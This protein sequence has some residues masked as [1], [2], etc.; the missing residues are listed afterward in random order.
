MRRGPGRDTHTQPPPFQELTG[1]PGSLV[2][3]KCV[4]TKLTSWIGGGNDVGQNVFLGAMD[5]VISTLDVSPEKKMALND[6]MNE[7]AV[8]LLRIPRVKRRLFYPLGAWCLPSTR[9]AR[10]DTGW[11]L[12]PNPQTSA[13]QT[14]RTSEA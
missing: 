5:H 6:S 11:S 10:A 8:S 14:R 9:P 13:R 4:L 2:Y 12:L 1:R 7:R 3:K